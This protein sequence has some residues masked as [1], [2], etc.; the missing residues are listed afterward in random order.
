MSDPAFR[1]RYGNEFPYDAS[2]SWWAA[3]GRAPPAPKDWAHSAARGVIADLQ[4]RRGIKWGF[5]NID[6]E[7]RVEIVETL[8]QIIRAAKGGDA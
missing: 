2:D 6:E 7:T 5:D 8:A 1:L 4:D 3:D